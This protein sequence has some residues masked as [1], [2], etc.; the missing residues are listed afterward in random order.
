MKDFW[1][2]R[3]ANRAYAY[4]TEPNAFF[5]SQIDQRPAGRILLP[6]EGEGRNAV[7]AAKLGWEVVAFDQSEAGEKK[8]MQLAEATQTSISYRIED[9][10]DFNE[11]NAFDLIFYGFFHVPPTVLQPVY[12]HLNTFVKPNGLILLEGF[13]TKNMGRGSGGPQNEAMLFTTSR[14]KSLLHDFKT[15][16]VWE[17]EIIL[18]EGPFHQG[19][20]CVIRAIGVK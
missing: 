7:Y 20:A 12:D 4:G 11:A 3:Y 17:E 1:N 19:N 5:K 15:L 10:M 6:A 14:V 8:A 18:N 13:S 16:E 9:A 2:D